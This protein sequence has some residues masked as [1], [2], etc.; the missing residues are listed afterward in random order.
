MDAEQVAIN[1]LRT[2]LAA[3]QDPQRRQSLQDQ[4]DAL[5]ASRISRARTVPDVEHR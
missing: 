1:A 3:E 5:L 2:V 4:L